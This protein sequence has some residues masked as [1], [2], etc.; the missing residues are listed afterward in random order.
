VDLRDFIW[1]ADLDFRQPGG[2]R[3]GGA[4]VTHDGRLGIGVAVIETGDLTFAEGGLQPIQISPLAA[5]IGSPVV[6]SA[7]FKG[8][9]D[10]TSQGA[11]S[12][13]AVTIPNLDFTSPAGRV[14]GLKGEVAF[15]SLA[16]LKA[17]PGQQLEIARVD[18]IVPL[19][20]LKA[21]FSVAN[22]VLTIAGGEADVGGGRVRVES[23]EVPLTPGAATRGV[24]FF[25]GVQLHDLVEASPF[26]DK[27]EFDARVS[28]RVPF[29]AQGSQV[30]IS[31]G[32]LRA[33]Q[34]GRLS[35]DRSALTGVEAAGAVQ[36]PAP[37]AAA[38]DPNS[39]FTDFAYQAMEN[40]AFD[41]LEAT[42]A[43]R[44][45]GR[46]GVLFHIVGRHDPPQK[47][48]IRLTVLDLIQRK[49]LGRP[50]PLPSGTGV[51]LTLDTTLNLDDLLADYGE[52]QRLHGSAAVQ[53]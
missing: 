48:Q 1:R 31:G 44:P 15:E 26:G 12:S 22:D 27:V 40:L 32:E 20:H 38:V 11:A 7:T 45:D 25:E 35:I 18:A 21:S 5:A 51:N 23:L 6:G 50:L 24:L 41:T 46:L 9:F 49:F 3:I 39:T 4:R 14:E 10:W 42:L 30:R 43:S 34:P 13:G 36:A 16:P 8:R 47:Q 17:A 28:G 52:Y 29:E 19:E 2:S 53:P 37:A 33:I